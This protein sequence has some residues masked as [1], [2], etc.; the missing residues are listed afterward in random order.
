[1]MRINLLGGAEKPVAYQPPAE[2]KGARQ[3]LALVLLLAAAAAPVA[4]LCIIWDTRVKETQ[5]E[6]AKEE[7]EKRRLEGIRQQIQQFQRQQ[8][9]LRRRIQTINQLKRGQTGPVQFLNA[10][11]LTVNRT[12][13]LWFR[14]V[15]REG[16]RVAMLGEAR[17]VN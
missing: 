9:L 8:Q 5:V 16:P 10:L 17:T 14:S 11:G 7:A 3:G 12:P 15:K 6:V 13:N 4:F 2:F 1:M